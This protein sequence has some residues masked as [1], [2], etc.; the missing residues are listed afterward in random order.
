MFGSVLLNALTLVLFAGCA[1]G[2][3]SCNCHDTSLWRDGAFS[4][5]KIEYALQDVEFS[6]SEDVVLASSEVSKEGDDSTEKNLVVYYKE[7]FTSTFKY[8]SGVEIPSGNTFEAGFPRLASTGPSFTITAKS[9]YTYGQTKNLSFGIPG[10]FKCQPQTD[11][12]LCKVIF[13]K[14]EVSFPYIMSLKH[15]TIPNCVCQSKG[16]WTGL[17]Y[18]GAEVKYSPM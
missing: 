11:P 18:Y 16:H 1:R 8:E 15:N 2:L 7:N 4:V 3:P 12:A 9:P 14:G 13:K 6:P 5:D 17:Q 10:R